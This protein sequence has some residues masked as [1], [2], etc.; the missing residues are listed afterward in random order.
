LVSSENPYS[1]SMP[2]KTLSYVAKYSKKYHVSVSSSDEAKG[3]VSG[4]G[5]FAYASKVTVT[6]TPVTANPF[7]TVTWYDTDLN[8][9]SNSDSYTFA[10]P[11]ADV[12]LSAD[13]QKV[14]GS[15]FTLGKYPQTV[16]EDSTLLNA[17]ASATDT[18]S[19]GYLE[20]GSD[21]YKKVTG[22]PFNS[23]TYKSISGNVT[24]ASG[25]TYYFKV[26]PIEWRVL[27]GKGTAAGLVMSEKILANGAYYTSTSNRTVSGS[28]VYPN[29][30]QY[31]TL[32]AMLNGYDGSAYSVDNFAGKG[33][34]DVAFTETEKAYITTTTV[35]NSA[36]TTESSS[37]PYACANTDDRIFALSYRDLLNTSY[38]FASSLGSS[39][40]R[41]GVL[42]DY[43]RATGALMSTDSSYYGNGWWWS[44]SPYA[45]YSDFA[46]YVYND[47]FLISNDVTRAFFGVRPS[48][49]VSIG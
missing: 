10:M 11:E 2:N 44:R 8:V 25:T 7:N 37:N 27:S 34:L 46:S 26:E 5:D 22:A 42:T 21:E 43:A 16:V 9:V 33:F 40:T 39:S 35:D 12:N 6:G 4:A 14:L 31:S 30:Y 18:D 48:F 29:N 15:S 13:F 32:R 41:C 28:T 49:T 1:F 17:L 36:G 24:F 20:Y 23:G 45:D 38:G 47:G 3:T 19:D